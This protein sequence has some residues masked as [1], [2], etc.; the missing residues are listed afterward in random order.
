M[1]ERSASVGSALCRVEE[2]DTCGGARILDLAICLILAVAII[3]L[4]ML[5][6]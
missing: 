3:T 5:A 6:L 2:S 1:S 4:L